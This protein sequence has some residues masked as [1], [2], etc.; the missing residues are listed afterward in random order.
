MPIKSRASAAP[1]GLQLDV[2]CILSEATHTV[3]YYMQI[4]KA[5]LIST[6]QSLEICSASMHK[7]AGQAFAGTFKCACCIQ[8]HTLWTEAMRQCMQCKKQY[9]WEVFDKQVLNG[10]QSQLDE[11]L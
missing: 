10:L 9:M 6:Y 1:G 7:P 5:D 11:S 2:L 3:A 4:Y 8:Y